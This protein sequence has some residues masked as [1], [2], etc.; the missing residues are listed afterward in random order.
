MLSCLTFPIDSCGL[1]SL[2]DGRSKALWTTSISAC[3]RLRCIVRDEIQLLEELC[4]MFCDEGWE[5]KC[6]HLTEHRDFT[7]GAGV[8]LLRRFCEIHSVPY[9]RLGLEPIR[10]YIRDN[11]HVISEIFSQDLDSIDC[12][13]KVPIVLFDEKEEYLG[14]IYVYLN[15]EPMEC[16]GIRSSL[17]NTLKVKFGVGGRRGVAEAILRGVNQYALD[18]G[19]KQILLSNPIGPMPYIAQKFGFDMCDLIDVK[20]REPAMKLTYL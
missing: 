12:D 16:I 10:E 5:K 8:C 17:L 19:I 18:K 3:T 2:Y 9:T 6:E 11:Y 1:L 4:T 13:H 7:L 15:T 20:E 14:H